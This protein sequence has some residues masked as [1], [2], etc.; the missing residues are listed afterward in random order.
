MDSSTIMNLVVGD[1]SYKDI[2]VGTEMA[3]LDK[4]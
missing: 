2:L 4:E 3:T 1:Y